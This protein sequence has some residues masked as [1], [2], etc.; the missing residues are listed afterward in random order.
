VLLHTKD[1]ELQ[2]LAQGI[3]TEQQNEIQVMQAWLQ[4]HQ[5]QQPSAGR[6]MK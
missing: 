5:A 4:R 1:R 2:N 3:I 6:T